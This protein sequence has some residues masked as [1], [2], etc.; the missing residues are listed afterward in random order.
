MAFGNSFD[1]D[2]AVMSEIN[3]TPLVDVMLVL[4][5]IF[6]L[7]VPVI[8]HSVN[9]NLAERDATPNNIQADTISLSLTAEAKLYWNKELIN[10]SEL[11]KRLSDAAGQQPQPGIQLRAD[12]DLRYGEVIAIM[13]AVQNSGIEA[14]GFITE[15]E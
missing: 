9:V 10:V 12:K 4:L 8:T 1:N 15:A 14:L 11:N 6:M 7:T 2:D 13:S 3:M 5:I